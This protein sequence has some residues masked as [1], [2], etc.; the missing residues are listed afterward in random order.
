MGVLRYFFNFLF[1][2][3]ALHISLG[4]SRSSVLHIGSDS[5]E[6]S[7]SRRTGGDS[8]SLVVIVHWV[9]PGEP[10]FPLDNGKGK[11]SEIRYLSGSENLRAAIQNVVVV[12]PNRVEP[13][14]DE[15]FAARYGPPFGVQVWCPDVLTS[16][17]VQVNKMVCFF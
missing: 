17:V 7:S 16:Y 13:S 11:I 1:P 2:C 15:V 5:T 4:P 3:F 8:D 10:A 9:A 14:Y 12:G 6:A